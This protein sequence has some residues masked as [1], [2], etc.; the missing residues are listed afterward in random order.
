M[1]AGKPTTPLGE[2]KYFPSE[3]ASQSFTYSSAGQAVAGLFVSSDYFN[4][5]LSE[6]AELKRQRRDENKDLV[7]EARL[8]EDEYALRL[9]VGDMMA[10]VDIDLVQERLSVR[11]ANHM[12]IEHAELLIA[13]LKEG[14]RRLAKYKNGEG[15]D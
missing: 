15:Y 6:N 5:L 10:C 13:L 1:T 12:R 9:E 14:Q 8:L 7:I 4:Q 11:L 2:I 3:G